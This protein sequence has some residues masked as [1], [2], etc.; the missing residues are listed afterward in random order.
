M[1]SFEA[2]A[3]FQIEIVG[4]ELKYLFYTPQNI[5]E[6]ALGL[7]IFLHGASARGDSIASHR[8]CALPAQ[9]DNGL[10]M[11]MFVLSPLCPLGTEWAKP[12]MCA[13]IMRLIDNVLKSYERVIDNAMVYLTGISMGGLGSVMLAARNP[14]RFAAVA[15]MCGGGKAVYARLLME[16]R[17]P[18]WFFHSA[19]DNVIGVEE[20]EALVDAMNEAVSELS[21]LDTEAAGA[22][23]G[24]A[25]ALS[26]AFVAPKFTRYD[27]SL[28]PGAQ[29]WM[30]GHNCWD[31]SFTPDLWAWMKAYK[32]S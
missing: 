20:T 10:G 14:S 29:A 9:L 21:K 19:D 17:I 16:H 24:A 23:A 26:K 15:P 4:E 27:T 22:G 5:T 18:F 13:K 30:V 31:R 2:I 28:D 7:L 1:T 6:N 11:D 12:D 3:G 32:L 8:G 25:D